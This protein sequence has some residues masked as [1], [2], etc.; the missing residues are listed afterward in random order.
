MAGRVVSRVFGVF[1]ICALTCPPL[2][3]QE[4][5]AEPT[6][7][8][9]KSAKKSTSSTDPN[10]AVHPQKKLKKS[11]KTT[12]VTEPP[13]P[14][15]TTQPPRQPASQTPTPPADAGNPGPQSYGVA[16]PEPAEVQQ[17]ISNT[18]QNVNELRDAERNLVH[19]FN[20]KDLYP[21]VDEVPDNSQ[22]DLNSRTTSFLNMLTVASNSFDELSKVDAKKLNSDL[23]SSLE[24]EVIA[25]REVVS[26]GRNWLDFMRK[27]NE[28]VKPLPQPSF[29]LSAA[30][31][32]SVAMVGLSAIALIIVTFFQLDRLGEERKK[33]TTGLI[34]LI[35]SQQLRFQ[36]AQ[37]KYKDV[38]ERLR[39]AQAQVAELREQQ[40]QASGFED[41]APK[42]QPANA[43]AEPILQQAMAR[44]EPLTPA[45]SATQMQSEPL[46]PP[47]PLS[48]YNRVRA[49]GDQDRERDTFQKRY[50]PQRLSC[51]NLE[52]YR[53][54][55]T[56]SLRFDASGRGNFM[57]AEDS[58]DIFC[59]PS[60]S[61]DFSQRKALEGVFLYPEGNLGTLRLKQP[62]RLKEDGNGWLLKEPG[63]FERDV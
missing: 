52:D 1:L 6:A 54:N 31:I 46:S 49:S 56:A 13:A 7:S 16:M 17:I 60:F 36:Q 62:A 59:F 23:R 20:R 42:S 51:L 15:P 58:G 44:S 40:Y 2:G 30:G 19:S 14:S 63:I 25:A 21:S 18:K 55:S 8:S 33:L 38:T 4:T 41:Y 5:T 34:T 50:S 29:L 27:L 57:A 47:T 24:N 61:V 53:Y 9:T 28:A 12:R 37:S 11:S 26:S 22:I 35:D 32:A 10:T 39:T 45:L 48:E 43:S 3:A